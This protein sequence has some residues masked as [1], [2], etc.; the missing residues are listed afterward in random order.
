MK[1][2]FA[3]CDTAAVKAATSAAKKAASEQKQVEPELV[4]HAVDNGSDRRLAPRDMNMP[5][6]LLGFTVSC[7]PAMWRVDR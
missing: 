6:P 7:V 3:L 4:D 5:G 1:K 2:A